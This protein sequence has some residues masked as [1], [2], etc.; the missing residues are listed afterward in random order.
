[1]TIHKTEKNVLV[2]GVVNIEIITYLDNVIELNIYIPSLL[3]C[4]VPKP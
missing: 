1:M 2:P 4:G 3:S